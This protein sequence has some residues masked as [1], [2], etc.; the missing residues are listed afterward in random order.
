MKKLVLIL[1]LV[2]LSAISFAD[3]YVARHED[4]KT[5][6]GST[7]YVV[8]EEN[9]MSEYNIKIQEAVERSWT[10]TPYKFITAKEFEGMRN[11]ISKSFIVKLQLKFTGDKLE[12]TYNFMSIVLGAA[13]KKH[14]DLPDICSLPISYKGIDD[15]VYA[16][17]LEGLLRFA[18]S[19]IKQLDSNPKLIKKDIFKSYNANKKLVKEKELWVLEKDLDKG[20]RSLVDLRK[21]YPHVVKI[22]TEEEIEKAIKEKNE[23]VIYLHKVGPE[24]NRLQAR[25]YKLLIG[26]GTDQ[27]YY[28]GYH[29]ISKGND[30]FLAKDLKSIK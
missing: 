5:F 3:R 30:G 19:H 17:K 2:C 16:Y 23:K 12:A 15:E 18:Q 20:V 1:C 27:L 26:A 6:L 9:L 24:G 25:C 13:V 21:N 14:T 11:D 28:Y 8:L 22:V 29:M 10:I 7:T 4:I